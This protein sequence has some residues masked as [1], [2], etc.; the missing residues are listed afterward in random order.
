MK[1]TG[2]KT[3]ITS[4]RF[5]ARVPLELDGVNIID[6]ED[7]QRE[8][9]KWQ[10][11]RAMLAAV[12]LPGWI[13]QR[14][15][16]SSENQ[17]LDDVA[18]IIFS[19]GSTGEPKGVPLTYRNLSSNTAAAADHFILVR[20]DRLLR[21]AAVL[22]QLRLHGDPV[23]A[24]ADR[25]FGG[26]LSRTRG[27]RKKSANCAKNIAA[28]ASLGTATF[29]RFYLRRCQPDDF[30]TMRIIICGAEKLP[31][32]LA[33]KS[34]RRS[35]ASCRWKATA[36]RNFRRRCATNVDRCR[37]RRGSSRCATRS[38]PS[39]HPLPG[40]A[41]RII[42]PDTEQP[43]PPGSEG[44]LW[45]KGPNV[46]PGY[47]DR[48]DLTAKAI[49]NG[50]YITGDMAKIDDDGFITITGRL[51]RFA[52]IGG[53]MVPLEKLEDDMHAVLGTGDR[54]LAV[55]SIPDERRGERLVVL[56]LPGL[57]MTPREIGKQLGERGIPNLWVPGERDYFEVKELPVLGTG[58]LDLRKVKEMA[59]E[60][61]KAT[62]R[63]RGSVLGHYRTRVGF[64]PI[65]RL[66]ILCEPNLSDSLRTGGRRG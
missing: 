37:C 33:R 46:M 44:L 54:V 51:S 20:D 42:D 36:A 5:L 50:W 10:K 58:K 12:L 48:P 9:T 22:P 15:V 28:P 11:I 8:I 38:A 52:K 40:M 60:V 30:R 41:C 4:K 62:P 18:T 61:A 2:M 65:G 25:R 56:H 29:L 49:K 13:L 26:A 47:L 45:V 53:E 32:A 64:T 6:L 16:V 17:E 1:Q 55:T 3:V 21:R 57:T 7:A 66:I 19:S 39:G 43:L 31:P 35:S 63:T 59:E 27:R 34:S 24:A 23:A 14:L